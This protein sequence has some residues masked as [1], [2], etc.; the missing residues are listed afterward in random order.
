MFLLK[1]LRLRN[2]IRRLIVGL[3]FKSFRAILCLLHF[4]HLYGYLTLLDEDV[5][6][7]KFVQLA[8]FF[9]FLVLLFAYLLFYEILAGL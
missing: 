8:N 3:C 9:V 7:D 1:R 6:F 5:L 2:K 4:L